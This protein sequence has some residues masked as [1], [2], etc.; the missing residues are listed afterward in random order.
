[1]EWGRRPGRPPAASPCARVR[2][3][4]GSI[5]AACPTGIR[6]ATAPQC[7]LNNKIAKKIRDKSGT[8]IDTKGDSGIRIESHAEIAVRP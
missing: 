7:C 6:T 8:E 4:F 3:E 5:L 1:M 2:I